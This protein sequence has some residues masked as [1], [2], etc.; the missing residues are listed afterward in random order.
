MASFLGL[1]DRN[2]YT[3]YILFYQRIYFSPH[4]QSKLK[5]MKDRGNK[6]QAYAARMQKGGLSTSRLQY[7]KLTPNCLS[8]M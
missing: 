5:S 7:A 3:C 2:Y 1:L 6:M 4:D 8:C